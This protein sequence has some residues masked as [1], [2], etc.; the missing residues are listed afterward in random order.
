M[1]RL[2]FRMPEFTRLLWSS[3]RAREVWSP[4][5]DRIAAAWT[6]VEQRSVAA[7]VRRC[8]IAVVDPGRLADTAAQA[9]AAGLDV[10]L[11][12]RI[13]IGRAPYES[14]APA[15]R[16]DQPFRQRLAIARPADGAGL[17]AAWQRGDQPAIA[18]LLGYPACCAAFFQRV[19]VEQRSIDTTWA[20]LGDAPA[21]D[22]VEVGGPAECNPLLRW[23]GV[24]AVPHL[25]CR[26]DCAASAALARRLAE[27]ARDAGLAEPFGWLRD[28]LD[29]PIEWSALHGIAEIK[30]PVVKIATATDATAARLRIRRPGTGWPDEGARG[31]VFPYQPPLRLRRPRGAAQ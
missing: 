12:D 26:F 1:I 9:R 19:W 27:V 4:R 5:V 29:W 7:G 24:R 25:P 10:V 20:M 28:M 15:P 22:D 31:L 8:A 14:T 21:S 18:D 13:A 16:P 3:P 23:L 11:L 6:E 2:D 17:A 30:S